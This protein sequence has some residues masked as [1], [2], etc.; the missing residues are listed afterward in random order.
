[1][2]FA[3]YRIVA[4]VVLA[5]AFTSCDRVVKI[6]FLLPTGYKGL[7]TVEEDPT[8]GKAKII[9]G[10]YQVHFSSDGICRLQSITFFYEWA[11][12]TARF[13]DGSNLPISDFNRPSSSYALWC[14]PS[15][16]MGKPRIYFFAGPIDEAARYLT[17]HQE[18]YSSLSVPE[19]KPPNPE[20][21]VSP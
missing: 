2:W 4:V 21:S 6:H 1:M 9:N 20:S 19:K 18:L 10:V 3:K 17:D 12:E 13:E 14:Y 8:A 16:G 15:P 5:F 11:E 7:L